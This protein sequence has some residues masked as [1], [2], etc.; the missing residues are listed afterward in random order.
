MVVS[1]TSAARSHSPTARVLVTCRFTNCCTCRVCVYAS[2]YCVRLRA[3][4]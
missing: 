2:V 4:A 1:C 3:R